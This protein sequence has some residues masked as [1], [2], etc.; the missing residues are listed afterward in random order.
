MND[1]AVARIA[2]RLQQV[3]HC[4][5]VVAVG[6]SQI[7]EPHILKV[8][9]AVH[10]ILEGFLDPANGAEQP[11][12]DERD[13]LD[14]MRGA[15]LGAEVALLLPQARHMH[16]ETSDVLG[17][18]HFILVDDDDKTQSG[19]HVVECLVDHAACKGTVTHDCHRPGIRAHHPIRLRKAQ[20]RRQGRGAVPR[21]EAVILALRAFGE[22]GYTASL[23]QCLHPLVAPRQ[24]L[25]DVAL[26]SDIENEVVAR[27]VEHPVHRHGQLHHAEIGGEVPPGSGNGTQQFAADFPAQLRHFVLR[28]HLEVGGRVNA[29]KQN[30]REGAFRP[31]PR[32]DRFALRC[33]FLVGSHSVHPLSAVMV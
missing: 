4:A 25:V 15:A 17:Y 5:V 29:G 23:T 1:H 6:R 28:K 30:R 20:R 32:R 19:T 2:R 22:A 16:G 24:H 27:A 7:V 11:V 9:T 21:A 3:D 14:E 12:S 10:G 33:F 26:V 18:G 31:R 8:I 13:L